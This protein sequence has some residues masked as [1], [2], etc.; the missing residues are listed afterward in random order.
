MARPDGGKVLVGPKAM[1]AI[2][3]CVIEDPAG[4]V[5]AQMS[6]WRLTGVN[7]QG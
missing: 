4:A 1:D 5:L 7:P 2:N 6:A 3:F